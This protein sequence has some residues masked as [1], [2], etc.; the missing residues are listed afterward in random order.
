MNGMKNQEQT[1]IST[2]D[3]MQRPTCDRNDLCAKNIPKF[4]ID[5]VLELICRILFFLAS[6]KFSLAFSH[7]LLFHAPACDSHPCP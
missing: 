4:I 7:A 6:I 3:T 2:A 1:S 5:Y